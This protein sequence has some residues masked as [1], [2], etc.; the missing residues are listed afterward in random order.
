MPLALVKAVLDWKV[1]VFIRVSFQVRKVR[2]TTI[3]SMCAGAHFE[4]SVSAPF[5]LAPGELT[6]RTAKCRST[7]TSSYE[8][9]TFN[10]C[11]MK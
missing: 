8:Y 7:A 4:D 1:V 2:D 10:G 5:A 6:I 3:V 11:H 9:S